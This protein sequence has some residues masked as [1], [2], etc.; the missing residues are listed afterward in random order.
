LSATD[1]KANP[2]SG[3]YP[4]LLVQVTDWP[5]K[6]SPKL[7]DYFNRT[8][9][10]G[11]TIIQAEL[12]VIAGNPDF[13]FIQEYLS[14]SEQKLGVTKE[15][16]KEMTAGALMNGKMYVI[17]FG[18]YNSQFDNY[19]PTIENMVD[20]FSPYE[21]Q[22]QTD[23]NKMQRMHESPI[24]TMTDESFNQNVPYDNKSADNET[25][26][27]KIRWSEYTDTKYAYSIDYPSNLGVGKPMV[28]K[29]FNPNVPGVVFSLQ[30]S[31]MTP[32]TKGR[33]RFICKRIPYW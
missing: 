7:F 8:G 13:K 33:G 15:K 22:S 11:A 6:G 30:N 27:G 24:P 9:F 3:F 29:D 17:S 25:I 19:L 21:I 28:A 14:P 12:K 2:G 1:Y 10:W 18:A 23:G 5:F 20:S 32:G 4:S 31:S 16:R 26:T